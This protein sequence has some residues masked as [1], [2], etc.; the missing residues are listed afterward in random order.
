[1]PFYSNEFIQEAVVKQNYAIYLNIPAYYVYTVYHIGS[2][3]CADILLIHRFRRGGE[4][5][6]KSIDVDIWVL[7]GNTYN[8]WS[9]ADIRLGNYRHS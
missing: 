8:C 1:M 6:V 3:A 2:C 9:A 5:K 7:C 4:L